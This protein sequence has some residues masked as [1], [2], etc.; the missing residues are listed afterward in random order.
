MLGAPAGAVPGHQQVRVHLGER[1]DG[2]ADDRLERGAAEV[3]PADQAVQARHAGEPLGVP[4]DVDRAGV[5]AA[6]EHH[7]AAPADLHDEGLIVDDQG[8]VLPGRAGPLL[9]GRGHAV[10]ELGGPVDLP[11]DQ[12][13]PVREQ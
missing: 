2:T 8:V 9:V 12:H 10:L 13:A 7:E 3:Q 5:R 11:S 6:G 1:V 4:D